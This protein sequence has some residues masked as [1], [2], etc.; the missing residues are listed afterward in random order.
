MEEALL[1]CV[2]GFFAGLVAVAGG[3]GLIQVPALFA[4]FPGAAPAV[5]LGTNKVSSIAGTLAATLRY[6][7][8][9]AIEWRALLVAAALAVA[10]AVL[11][12]WTVTRLPPAFMRPAVLV[13]LLGVLA[14]S[15]IHRQ[16]GITAA[17]GEPHPPQGEAAYAAGVGFYDGFFGPGT[18]AFLMFGLVKWFRHGFLEAAARA[19]VLNLA[20][21]SGALGV[22]LAA[23]NVDLTIGLPMAAANVSG[24]YVG[25]S[26]A[27]KRGATFIRRAFLLVVAALIAKL[28]WDV[29]AGP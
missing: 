28:A 8:S 24:G 13:L 14:Y 9:V 2:V 3:G 18:G 4:V 20:S 15:V 26:T 16:M 27:V 12:A 1:L 19:R 29:A 23:G 21:N 6:A 7:R 5:L 10:A 17:K 11:G 22:F 25:A